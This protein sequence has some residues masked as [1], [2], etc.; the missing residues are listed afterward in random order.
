MRKVTLSL[1]QPLIIALGVSFL[2]LTLTAITHSQ[3]ITSSSQTAVFQMRASNLIVPQA[4][5]YSLSGLRQQVEITSVEAEARILEQVA[6]TTMDVGLSNPTRQIQEAEMLIPVPEGAV[7][8]SFSFA[9]SA[10]ESTAKLLPKAEAQSIYRSIVAK[11]RDPG[12]RRRCRAFVLICGFGEGVNRETTSEGRSAIDLPVYRC[13][14]TRSRFVGVR[15][16]QRHPFQRV[17]DSRRRYAESTD[18]VR[19]RPEG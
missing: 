8:R 12:S 6:T 18:R 14:T 4:R 9:G 10:K 13:E 11:L 3:E 5:S 1:N 19:A 7:V 15:R 16:V 2:A 17:S